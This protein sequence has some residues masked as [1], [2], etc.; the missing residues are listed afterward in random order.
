MSFCAFSLKMIGAIGTI[1][2]LAGGIKTS[3][4]AA[5]NTRE[6]QRVIR[7]PVLGRAEIENLQR[8]VTLGH[9]DWAKDPRLVASQ[10]LERMAADFDG[11][12]AELDSRD[13]TAVGR[14]E[15]TMTFEWTPLDGRAV[16]R[17][18]VKRFDWL[19]PIAKDTEGIVWVPAMTEIRLHE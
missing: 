15:R 6:Q 19:L 12:A 14:G 2:W 18:T 16:Y 3:P 10:E 17:V 9:E 7:Y 5:R 11:D 13:P 8:W 1:C 4:D